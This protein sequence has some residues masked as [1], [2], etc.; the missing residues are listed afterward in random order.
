[1]RIH[2]RTVQTVDDGGHRH[3]AFGVRLWVKEHLGVHHMVGFRTLQISPSHV[4]KI[5]LVQQ[6][7]CACVVNVEEA[8]QVGEGIGGTQILNAGIWQLDPIP[9]GQSKDEFWL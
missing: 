9:L 8:L 7:A 6:H 4:V 2:A 1:L 3:A 5:L